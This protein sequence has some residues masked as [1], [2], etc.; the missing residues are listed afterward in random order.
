MEKEILLEVKNLKKYFPMKNFFGIKTCDVKAVDD[1]SS[2]S[3]RVRPSA[4][5][6][7]PAAENPPWDVPFCRC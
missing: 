2:S 1:V 3:T 4:L 5:W 7:S 6:A